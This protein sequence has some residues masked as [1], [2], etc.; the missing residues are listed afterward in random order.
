LWR[1]DVATYPL[2]LS[3]FDFVPNLAFLVGAFF[4]VRTALL[5]RG[6]WCARMLMA[7]TLLIFLGGLL[8]A[9]WKLL[10]TVGAG[11]VRVFS[12][13]QFVLLAP[14]F[15]AMLVA[16]VLMARRERRPE[17]EERP[18]LETRLVPAI[19]AWK[20][21]FLAVMTVASVAALGVLAYLAIRKGMLLVGALFVLAAVAT[22]SLG[23]LAGGE[24]T[25]ARQWLAEG[26][27]TVGQLAFALGAFLLYRRV[28]AEGTC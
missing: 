25:V 5:L 28:R 4:L 16:A 14:G 11:D 20:L 18:A 12:E 7:G 10:Y 1:C 3:L 6:K 19:A 15:L 26:T 13:A 21:P 9:V 23:G 8:K 24:Q 22:L 2:G 17:H 27:N